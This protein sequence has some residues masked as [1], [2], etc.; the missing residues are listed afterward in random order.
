MLRKEESGSI[1]DS[2]CVDANTNDVHVDTKSSPSKQLT[3]TSHTSEANDDLDDNSA[4]ILLPPP[5]DTHNQLICP[6]SSTIES[7]LQKRVLSIQSHVIHG[8][9]FF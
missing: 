7:V 9:K 1:T 4:D 3:A 6:I 2:F 5:E 8:C